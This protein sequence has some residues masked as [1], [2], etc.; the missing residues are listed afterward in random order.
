[1]QIKTEIKNPFAFGASLALK[2]RIIGMITADITTWIT[3]L[4]TWLAVT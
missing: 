3:L 4:P 1:M 2:N